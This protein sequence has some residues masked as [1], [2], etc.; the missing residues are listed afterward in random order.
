[1]LKINFL[2][3][4]ATI[5]E[6]KKFADAVRF[7]FNAMTIKLNNDSIDKKNKIVA[8]EKGKFSEEEVK[9]AKSVIENLEKSNES[10]EEINN[11]LEPIHTSVLEEMT[12][13]NDKGFSNDCDAVCNVLRVIACADNSK[14]YKYAICPCFESEE[15]YK[16]ME[17]LHVN[18][19]VNADGFSTN[20][21]DRVANYKKASEELDKIIRNTFSMPIETKYTTPLKI[22]LNGEDRKVLHNCYVRGF[23]NKFKKKDDSVT[24]VGRNYNTAIKKNKDGEIDYTTMSSDIA[25]LVTA[26]MC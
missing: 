24:F 21:A 16:A 26:K 14:L 20:S 17:E 1:M 23:S 2:N 22:K 13:A 9:A 5:E 11:E 12:L 8:N 10:L 25:K 7:E 6:V 19:S 15:L 4:K 3:E 18:N